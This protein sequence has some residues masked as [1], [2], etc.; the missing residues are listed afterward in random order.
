MIFE[1][2]IKFSTKWY[3]KHICVMKFK[4]C[5]IAFIKQKFEQVDKEVWMMTFEETIADLKALTTI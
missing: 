2:N 3:I 4:Y 5:F 1:L